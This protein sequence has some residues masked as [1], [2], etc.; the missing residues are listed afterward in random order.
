MRKEEQTWKL[1]LAG[2]LFSRRDGRGVVRHSKQIG[3]NIKEI[4]K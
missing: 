3:S 4:M 1:G 2:R